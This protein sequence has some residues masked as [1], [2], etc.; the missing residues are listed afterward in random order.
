[1]LFAAK[2]AKLAFICNVVIDS[3]KR[4]IKAFCGD[5]E[6]AHETGCAFVLEMG[7]VKAVT[8][9]IAVTSNGGYPMDQNVY[10]AGKSMT[11]GEACVR[12]GGVIIVAAECIDGHGGES[13]YRYF[14]DSS[15][16]KEV[17][18][19][20]ELVSQ[21]DTEVD[22]WEAQILARVLLHTTVILVSDKLPRALTESM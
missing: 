10:Q 22:Q 13:F 18:D 11:A 5:P 21:E 6:E 2:E 17:A 7:S 1:M 3:E 15:S 8:A 9:D 16:P 19:R 14:A 12:K 20:I 4:I